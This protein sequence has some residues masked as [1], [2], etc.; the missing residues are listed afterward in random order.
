MRTLAILQNQWLG[1]NV[2]IAK[3]AR[4][5]AM[6]IEIHNRW[7]AMCLFAGCLTGRRLQ[8]AF[9]SQ[10]INLITWSDASR[11]AGTHSAAKF[12]ADPVHIDELM[13]H[14]RPDIVILFG[15]IADEG[16]TDWLQANPDRAPWKIIRSP[17]P[18]ARGASTVSSLNDVA[19]DW[20]QAVGL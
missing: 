7:V 2:T 16:F 12:P 9:V 19:R 13:R 8:K 17:H 14:V 3:L 20:R 6:P 15:R 5:N 18:A 1:P 11:E 4:L 10:E